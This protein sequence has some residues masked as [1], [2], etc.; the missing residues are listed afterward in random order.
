MDVDLNIAGLS[1]EAG[2][3]V[4]TSPD[5]HLLDAARTWTQLPE[6]RREDPT[7]YDRPMLKSP[8]W[9]PYIPLYYYVGGAAGASLVLGAAAQLDG[10][11][12]LDDFVRRC[13]WIGIA[14]SS[15]GGLL[16]VADLGRPERFLAM[17]RVFR[18]TSPMNMG[19]WILAA[20]PSAA[21][22]AGLF[23]RTSGVWGDIGEVAGYSA[24]VFGAMLAT[25]TGV[26]LANSAVP[27]WQETR[28]I[29]PVLFGASAMAS[30]ASIF[31]LLFDDPRAHRVTYLFGLAGR[32]AE[33]AAGI[34]MERRASRVPSIALPLRSGLTGFAWKTATVLTAAS[35][36]AMLLPSQTRR[37]RV[38]A[39]VLGTAGSLTLRFAVHYAG[40][41][42]AREPLASF[43]QQRA[44]HGAAELSA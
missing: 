41:R 27:L 11:H 15:L 29:L 20:A 30:S 24:G 1:G 37:K 40:A 26:L 2:Q 5:R 33:L 9:K 22:T 14:G 7:Y 19:A 25:Y 10:S 8:V 4:T 21:I 35:L 31:D 38:I 13:H 3:Q 36:V 18:P 44:G 32:T 39:G 28:G 34:V 43:H 23:A 42:S 16:L 17:L 12:A 6:P